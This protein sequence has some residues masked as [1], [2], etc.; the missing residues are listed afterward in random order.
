MSDE[1]SAEEVVQGPDAVERVHSRREGSHRNTANLDR[2]A[3][4]DSPRGDVTSDDL[5]DAPSSEDHRPGHT[6]NLPRGVR[7][8]GA[9]DDGR[10]A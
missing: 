3:A 7:I 2:V 6:N 1:E 5:R 10:F 8:R 4:V 9:G